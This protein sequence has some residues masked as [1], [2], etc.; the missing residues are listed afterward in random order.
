MSGG[1]R[2]ALL[3]LLL[4]GLLLLASAAASELHA[5]SCP[6][7]TGGAPAG[8]GATAGTFGA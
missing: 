5:S 4:A 2:R 3:P 1:E 6:G 7:V 8:T